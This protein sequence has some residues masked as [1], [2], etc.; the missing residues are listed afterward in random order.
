MRTARM[1]FAMQLLAWYNVSSNRAS[2]LVVARRYSRASQPSLADE[3]TEPRQPKRVFA[4]GLRA[5]TLGLTRPDAWRVAAGRLPRQRTHSTA[6]AAHAGPCLGPAC[7]RCPPLG[8]Q[9]AADTRRRQEAAHRCAY[10]SLC[11][12]IHC[13]ARPSRARRHER[14]DPPARPRTQQ[15]RRCPPADS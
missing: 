8:Q 15:R 6:G 4:P 3:Q 9:R 10:S 2:S 7:P 5:Y 1:L 11:A 13:A 12:V 14:A